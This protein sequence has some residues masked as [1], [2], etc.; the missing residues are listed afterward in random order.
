LISHELHG[1]DNV[2]YSSREND[3]TNIENLSILHKV[4]P[5][6]VVR[7]EVLTACE[8]HDKVQEIGKGGAGEP[9]NTPESVNI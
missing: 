8:Y 7:V 9:C 5:I 3:T 6:L 4:V 2:E 1:R